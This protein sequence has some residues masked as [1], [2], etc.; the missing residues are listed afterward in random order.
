M[1][2]ISECIAFLGLG[3]P[4]YKM[5]IN[6][7]PF[8]FLESLEASQII[9]VIIRYLSISIYRNLKNTPHGK[10]PHRSESL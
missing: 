9:S 1:N 6:T 4:I 10:G 7:C 8:Y 2:S 3:L 5:I